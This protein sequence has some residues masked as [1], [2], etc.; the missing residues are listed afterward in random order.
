MC[1]RDSHDIGQVVFSQFEPDAFKVVLESSSSDAQ[2]IYLSEQ[3]R[4]GADH[5]ELGALLGERWQLPADLNEA[6]RMH[7]I[8]PSR[9]G[10]NMVRDCLFVA[11]LL[12]A[13]IHEPKN[14]PVAM[15]EEDMPAWV[16]T[17]F[18][19]NFDAILTELDGVEAEISLASEML[20]L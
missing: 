16:F 13:R 19:T 11:N 4:F 17:Q 12:S 20:Q 6:I 1:I 7:H 15:A 5:S 18:G 3:M 2:P 14:G 8:P 10:K 9:P